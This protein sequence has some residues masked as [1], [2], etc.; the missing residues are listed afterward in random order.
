ML[1]IISG[2]RNPQ[3]LW[4]NCAK[5]LNETDSII[6]IAGGVELLDMPE[7][8]SSIQAILVKKNIHLFAIGDDIKSRKIDCGFFQREGM[9]L[10]LISHKQFADLVIKHPSSLTW[11]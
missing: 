4:L 11:F 9:T 1:H 10:S 2:Y 6:F 8:A 7:P 3:S 5:S